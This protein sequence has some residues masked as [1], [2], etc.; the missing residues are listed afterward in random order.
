ML[1]FDNVT[2]NLTDLNNTSILFCGK[3]SL[4]LDQFNFSSIGMYRVCD[5]EFRAVLLRV[6]FS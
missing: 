4:I 5:V 3:V 1:I 2:A 6:N